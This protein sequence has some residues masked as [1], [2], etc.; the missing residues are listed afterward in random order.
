MKWTEESG[1]NTSFP[2]LPIDD[3]G[4]APSTGG[5]TKCRHYKR[6]YLRKEKERYTHLSRARID[7]CMHIYVCYKYV[8]TYIQVS[9]RYSYMCRDVMHSHRRWEEHWDPR[10]CAGGGTGEWL[11]SGPL[12]SGMPNGEGGVSQVPGAVRTL[13]GGSPGHQRT[14]S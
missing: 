1:C 8:H 7:L 6:L 5:D 14:P 3:E 9:K 4:K 11:R 2:A 13:C 10:G 12:S